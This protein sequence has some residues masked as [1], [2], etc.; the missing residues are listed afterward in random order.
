MER[1][2]D[3]MSSRRDEEM[4]QELEGELRSSHP[5]HAQEWKEA[6]PPADDD[7]ALASGPV[8]PPG[9]PG[10]EIRPLQGEA[11]RLELTRI[12]GR[13]G[14]P[15][16]RAGLL[17]QLERQSAAA[18]V[19]ETVRGLPDDGDRS[20]ADAGEVVSALDGQPD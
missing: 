20:Y 1:G 10:T 17:A 16:D 13:T 9:E 19:V 6:E 15:A 4:K 5:T 7:P 12:L 18:D 14:F 3:K 2:S 8:T 11:L